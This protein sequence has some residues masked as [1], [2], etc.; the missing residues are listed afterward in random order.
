MSLIKI[1]QTVKYESTKTAGRWF[2]GRVHLV[3]GDRAVIKHDTEPFYV[4]QPCSRLT[5]VEPTRRH[6]FAGAPA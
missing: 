2:T 1:N 6:R 3:E 4:T 5:I